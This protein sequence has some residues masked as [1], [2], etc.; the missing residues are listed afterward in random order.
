MTICKVSAK[1]IADIYEDKSLNTKCKGQADFTTLFRP[2]HPAL[3]VQ[4]LLI[5]F[6]F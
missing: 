1:F 6:R 3:P 4:I 2:A 5:L